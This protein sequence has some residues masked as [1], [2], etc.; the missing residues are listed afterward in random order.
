MLLLP[1]FTWCVTFKTTSEWGEDS[2]YLYS[3]GVSH[4]SAPHLSSCGPAWPP[5][6]AGG[7][8]RPAQCRPG[9]PA[10]CRGPPRADNSRCHSRCWP[11][12]ITGPHCRPPIKGGC[13]FSRFKGR[14]YC[15]SKERVCQQVVFVSVRESL[16]YRALIL[17]HLRSPRIDSKELIPPA[18]L[19]CRAGTTTLFLLGC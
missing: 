10:G 18:Y 8:R 6:P 5:G 7:S 12:R 2:S 19:G 15:N 1:V 17:I 11:P 14:P 13:L 4:H 9:G 3:R 16:L